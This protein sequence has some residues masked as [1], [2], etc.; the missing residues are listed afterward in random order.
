[1]YAILEA[2]GRQH[3]VTVGEKLKV[4]LIAAEAGSEVSFDKVLMVKNGEELKIGR[5]YVD[6]ALVK[7][8]VIEHGKG[9]KVIIFKYRRK[10]DYRRKQ[11]HRQ[12][13]TL[14]EITAI[15]G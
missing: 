4:E 6:G 12:P 14:L 10:K 3:R 7:A 15:E 2:G 5:P 13:Y 11:G 1:M 9:K 8:Q